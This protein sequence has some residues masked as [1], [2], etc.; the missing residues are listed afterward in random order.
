MK[1]LIGLLMLFGAAEIS[2]ADVLYLQSGKSIRMEAYSIEG[3]SIR[4]ILSDKG[5]L[6]FP[7]EWVR[8]IR[9]T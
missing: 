8:E 4:V 7:L 5:E 1:R 6:L 9:I 2:M 3:A